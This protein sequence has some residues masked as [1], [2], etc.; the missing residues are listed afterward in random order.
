[1]SEL[2]GLWVSHVFAR[3]LSEKLKQFSAGANGRRVHGLDPALEIG[4]N[5]FV[6]AHTQNRVRISGA[7]AHHQR[8]LRKLIAFNQNQSL[9]LFGN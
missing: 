1:M 5:R 3:C 6:G 7:L 4:R 9:D 8:D 2:A